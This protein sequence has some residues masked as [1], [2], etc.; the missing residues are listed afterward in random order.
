MES[1]YPKKHH[2]FYTHIP[3]RYQPY[4]DELFEFAFQ[5]ELNTLQYCIDEFIDESHLNLEE[6]NAIDIG[7]QEVTLSSGEKIAQGLYV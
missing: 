7:E 3:I 4:L 1:G 5:R 2:K 6:L